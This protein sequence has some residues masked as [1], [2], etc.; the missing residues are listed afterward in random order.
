[1]PGGF[2][3]QVYSQPAAAIAGDRASQNP[4]ASYDAGP[5]GLVSGAS[6]FVGRFAWVTGA[7]DPNNEPTVANSSGA[8][9]PAGFLMR[10]QQGLN[11]TFLSQAGMQV[12]PG[13]QTAL[14]IQ[15][16]FWV[17]NDGSTEATIGQKAYANLADG[18]VTF[19]AT[20]SPT[21]GPSSTGSTIAASTFSVTGSIANDVLT[22]TAV[23]SGT[24]V[25]GATIS[26]TGIASGTKVLSQISGAAG[27]VGTYRVS[28]PDQTVASTTVSGTYGT[29]TIGTLT[30]TPTFAVG[31]QL[32]A[33]GSVVAGTTI[34]QALTGSGGSGSTFA[35]D[36]NTVVGSQVISALVSVETKFV[37]RSAG[38]AGALIK[39]SSWG[40]GG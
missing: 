30:T 4:I 33:T 15:G 22:V 21:T 20:G 40:V 31:Q 25:A 3:T 27:G 32:N 35:V 7:V 26:G 24:I 38:P 29:L 16:D 17:V 28:I 37:A 23:S 5:G 9:I 39:I 8:G 34:T 14:Q 19:A 2:Q 13:A 11:T 36:N 10:N 12:Q 18:K 6:L 1:M